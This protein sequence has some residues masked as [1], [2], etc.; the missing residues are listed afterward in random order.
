MVVITLMGVLAVMAAPSFHRAIERARADVAVANLQAVWAAQRY[1]WIANRRYANTL[2]ELTDAQLVDPSLPTP[3]SGSDPG[4][5]S[6]QAYPDGSA[7]ATP[8]LNAGPNDVFQI[9]QL[10]NVTGSVHASDGTLI[11]PPQR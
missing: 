8:R 3:S 5:Y 2:G 10:G 11:T 9:D 1:F 7:T 6:Y 4:W